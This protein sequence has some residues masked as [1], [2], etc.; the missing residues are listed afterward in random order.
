MAPTETYSS[1]GFSIAP[2]QIRWQLLLA[3]VPLAVAAIA[4]VSA[5]GYRV[6][7][8]SLR[9]QAIRQLESVRDSKKREVERQF[10]VTEDE[11]VTMARDPSTVL[12]VKQ[13]SRATRELDDNPIT[14]TANMRP[15]MESL[16]K[17]L[18]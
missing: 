4:A 15:Q 9:E 13:L 1:R 18:E 6:A 7:S 11:V 3:F 16:K 2:R 17:Y 5:V 14:E 8:D 12:A 10:R